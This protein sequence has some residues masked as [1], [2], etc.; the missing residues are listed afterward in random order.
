[1]GQHWQ[2]D[3]LQ[4]GQQVHLGDLHTGQHLQGKV[5]HFLQHLH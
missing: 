2:G 1:M 3:F 4:F 5:L